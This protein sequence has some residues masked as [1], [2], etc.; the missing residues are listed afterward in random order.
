ML[1]GRNDGWNWSK[2]ISTYRE[3]K[4]A[5]LIPIEKEIQEKDA[6]EGILLRL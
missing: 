5:P 2:H 6:N 3:L 4:T 1:E